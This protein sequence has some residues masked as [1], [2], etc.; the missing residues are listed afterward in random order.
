MTTLEIILLAVVA[1]FGIGGFSAGLI[2]AV[3]S[4]VG[5]VVGTVVATRVY[6]SVAGFALPLF[7]GNQIAA[8]VTSFILIFS[9]VSAVVGIL[10]RVI[11][12]AYK[13]IAIFPGLK[14]LNRLGGLVFG[15]LEGAIVVGVM[16]NLV[17]R[18]PLSPETV[19][20]LQD[21]FW[22]KNFLAIGG[23][24]LPLFPAAVEKVTSA[25]G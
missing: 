12:K 10:V 13:L 2:Q 23:W 20:M 22:T 5:A 25:R 8:A 21:S 9:V 19:R 6:E 24:L 16:L 4:I 14:S 18:L 3:G 17:M 15:L 7:G 1:G 11:D